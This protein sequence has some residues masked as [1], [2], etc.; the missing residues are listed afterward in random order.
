[1]RWMVL[2]R[3][4]EIVLARVCWGSHG[5]DS[6]S[7]AC[8]LIKT[9]L[10]PILTKVLSAGS[11]S[12]QGTLGEWHPGDKRWLHSSTTTFAGLVFYSKPAAATLLTVESMATS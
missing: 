7:Y 2:I 4:F 6:R 1:M 9:A 5:G 3:P 12:G 11:G 10:G 8:L